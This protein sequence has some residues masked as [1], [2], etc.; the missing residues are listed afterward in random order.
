MPIQLT[1]NLGQSPDL[2]PNA[3]VR[4][5]WQERQRARLA[6]VLNTGES[7]AILLARGEPMRDGDLL[8]SQDDFYVAVENSAEDLFEITAANPI[9]L[10]RL[11]YHIANMAGV[12]RLAM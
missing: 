9:A 8:A 3:T 5:T 6:V 12:W 1:Q 10:M 11:V 4:L 7:V 2:K